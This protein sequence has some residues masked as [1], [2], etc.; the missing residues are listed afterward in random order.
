MSTAIAVEVRSVEHVVEAHTIE[1]RN[2]DKTVAR[3]HT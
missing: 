2:V 3:R 1:A